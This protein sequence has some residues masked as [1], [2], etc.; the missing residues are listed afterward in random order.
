MFKK[1]LSI[2]TFLIMILYISLNFSEK[3][4]CAN[5]N[6]NEKKPVKVAVLL[7]NFTDDYI[8]L[9]REDLENIQ[10]ENPENVEFTFYDGKSN[11]AVQNEQLD[12]VLREG[13]D[14]I[15]LHLINN[16]D[17]STV[18]RVINQVS[19]ANVPLI[20]FNREPLLNNIKNYK[21]S[22]YIGLDAKSD[23]IMQGELLANE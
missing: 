4:I 23:G 16:R 1:I 18:K 17:E 15:L 12:K 2:M 6:I 21:R 10:K 9:V 5:V 13:T 14:L 11:Q 8:S 19:K 3:A 20:F 22:L 7:I